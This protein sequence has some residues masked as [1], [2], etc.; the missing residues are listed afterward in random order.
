MNLQLVIPMS[1]QGSRFLRAGFTEPKPL[2]QVDG[3]PMIAWVLKMF[4]DIPD[5][6]F[7]CRRE[8]LETTSMRKVLLGLR[9][10]ATIVETEGAKLGPVAALLAAQDQISD[11]R[12]VMVSYC[13]YYMHWDCRRF[14]D[15]M[16]AEKYAGAIPCYTGFH[17]HLIPASNL[18]A[19]CRVDELGDL[20]EIREKFSFEPDKTKAL[21]SPGAYYFQSGEILKR[22]SQRQVDSNDAL[23]GEF[24]VSLV[25]N[26]LLR[27][28][29]RIAAPANVAHFCQWGTPE[30]LNEYLYWTQIA[31]TRVK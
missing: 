16:A 18:Y 20:V 7:I 12:P 2:I 8:H 25:Y 26:H 19:S 3:H 30:D 24:Y 28:G 31:R 15:L 1:G 21:H 29:L 22:Y 10:K 17:P 13:D 27:D 11:H 4:G 23:N 14:L 9:P 6:V 5:P